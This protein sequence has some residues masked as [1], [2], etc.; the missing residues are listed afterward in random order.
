MLN[1]PVLS[2]ES[3]VLYYKENIYRHCFFF[4]YNEIALFGLNCIPVHGL[5]LGIVYYNW[6]TFLHAGL[7]TV[8]DVLAPPLY[9]HVS[10]GN[11]DWTKAKFP[12]VSIRIFHLAYILNTTSHIKGS[13]VGLQYRSGYP[14][15]H[16][17]KQS[18]EADR[19]ISLSIKT[20]KNKNVTAVHCSP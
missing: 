19:H 9:N 3:W 20:N 8:I 10:I 17:E 15:H 5:F 14:R 1:K 16:R 7:L 13:I 18:I 12:Y 11:A 2:P 6:I 4:H